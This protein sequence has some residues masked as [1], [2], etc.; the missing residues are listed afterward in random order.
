MSF[1]FRRRL[2]VLEARPD[3]LTASLATVQPW[4]DVP[5]L[6]TSVVVTT[7]DNHDLAE[8]EAAEF[9]CDVWSRRRDYLPSLVS[10]ADGVRKAHQCTSGLVVLSDAADATTS[11]AP[12][13]STWCLKEL[14]KY[15]WPCGGALVTFVAPE[16]VEQAS[17]A[18]QGAILTTPIGG[19]R[20][21]RFS[22]PVSI[23]ASVERLFPAQFVLNGH[24]GVNLAIDMGRAAVLRAGD[25]RLV[26]TERS[27]PHFAP[28]LFLR[29]RNRS[30]R[31]HAC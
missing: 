26:V 18:G 2:E 17:A 22:T 7:D 10:V 4:L 3:V 6:G 9:A 27:G 28:E 12:G 30:L 21:S 11:G 19:R 8:R 20:D 16:V 23:P 29:C 14:L 1:A 15:D 13:D 24:L 5:E 31:G 25:V